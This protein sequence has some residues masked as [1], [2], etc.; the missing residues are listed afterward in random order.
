LVTVGHF[1]SYILVH[2]LATWGVFGLSK[3][4]INCIEIQMSTEIEMPMHKD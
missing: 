3:S 4:I 2:G 1:T